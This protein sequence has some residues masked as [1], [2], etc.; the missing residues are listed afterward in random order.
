MTESSL[1][2]GKK[3]L[4]SAG[5]NL[6]WRRQSILWW[7]F[8]VNAGLAALGTAPAFAVLRRA[9][10]HSLAGQQLVK[11]FDL[12]MFYELQ[13]V[14]DVKLLAS[15]NTSYVFAGLFALFMLFVSGGILEAYRQD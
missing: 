13:R 2:A 10:G 11:G 7:V 6:V 5:A 1:A 14:P 8:L 9:L 3:G 15:M 12:G 4:V